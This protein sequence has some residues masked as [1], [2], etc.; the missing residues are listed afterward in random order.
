MSS[1]DLSLIIPIFNE[2]ESLPELFSRLEAL[3]KNLVLSTEVIFINDGSKDASLSMLRELSRSDSTIRVISFSR[4]FGH[5]IAITAGFD[6]AVGSAA[7]V[8]DADLQ[9]PPEVINQMVDKWKEGYNIV[10]GIRSRRLGESIFKKSTAKIFYR[11]LGKM[12][13]IKIPHDVG[14]FR[15][16]DRKALEHFKSMRER[17]RYVRGMFAWVGFKQTG[18]EYIREERF[19]GETKYPLKRMIAFAL[20][21][22]ISFSNVPL[23]MAMT[24]GFAVS[25][26]S[27]GYGIFAILTKIF[28]VYS[29][30]GWASITTILSFLGGIQLLVLGIIGEYVG[31]IYDEVKQR[32]LYIID[33]FLNGGSL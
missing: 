6:I 28:G 19:A 18:V 15:L 30:S 8:M 23:K 16:V 5:Q 3:R 29:I 2:E 25:T 11:I 21:G 4:N 32:P 17:A 10:Y 27:F 14:D 22:I 20:D 1:R 7:V 9:D 33:E 12:T 31:R 26:L 24:L 13:D